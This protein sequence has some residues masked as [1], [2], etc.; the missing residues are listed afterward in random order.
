MVYY[1][2]SDWIEDEDPDSLDELIDL[3][4]DEWLMD[5]LEQV[6]YEQEAEEWQY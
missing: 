5:H 4:T 2:P 1:T 6:N 3:A